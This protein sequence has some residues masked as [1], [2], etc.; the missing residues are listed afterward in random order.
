MGHLRPDERQELQAALKAVDEEETRAVRLYA[1][2]K[3]TE[4][5]WDSLWREWQDK[6]NQIRYALRIITRTSRD[7]HIANL[8]SALE[9]ISQ[10][11]IVYN[12]L[13]C[14][15]RR[16]LLQQMVERVILD[17]HGNARLKFRTPFA[18]LQD[19]SDEVRSL[20]RRN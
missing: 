11:G 20:S 15:D 8:D 6:R 17:P 18:Y 2:G 14:D 10:V 5:I 3:I 16:E 9:I 7:A 13:S 1:A 4:S 12:S 19:I